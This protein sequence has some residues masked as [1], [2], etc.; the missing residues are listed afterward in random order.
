MQ[1]IYDYNFEELEAKIS[2]LGL[3]KYKTQQVFD[4]LYRKFVTDFSQMTSLSKDERRILRDCFASARND[5]LLPS[6]KKFEGKKTVKYLIA[7]EDGLSIESVVI[8]GRERKTLCLSSQ[9]GCSFSCKFCATGKM[10]FKRNL[11]AGEIVIQFVIAHID[12]HTIDNIVFMGMGEPL[13]NLDNVLKSMDILNDK[14]GANFG[15]RR[16]TISTAGIIT[17]IRNL[18]K[19]KQKINLAISLHAANDGKRSYLMPLNKQF[20]IQEL[21]KIASEYMRVSG[22]R[23]TLEYLLLK[24]FNDTRE[25]ANAL[26]KLVKNKGFHINLIP[27]NSISNEFQRS[28]K[29]KEFAKILQTNHINATIRQSQGFEIAAA[30]GMLAGE[31][32]AK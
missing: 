4:W 28:V 3:P 21:I 1:S 15:M 16:F 31:K 12:G 25:D 18:I 10:G 2:S 8:Q 6:Y 11:T 19:A 9:I 32:D 20:P 30:C 5:T 23:I 13:L 14:R 24:D 29:E 17:G 26:A 27:Y 7:F 22:R